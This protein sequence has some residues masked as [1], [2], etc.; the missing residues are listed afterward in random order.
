MKFRMKADLKTSSAADLNN[1]GKGALLLAF[2]ISA[3]L[4]LFVLVVF[5]VRYET[6]DDFAIVTELSGYSSTPVSFILN[7]ITSHSLY[8]LYQKFPSAPWYGLLIYFCTFLA[9]ALLINVLLRAEKPIILFF[10]GPFF[11]IVFFRAYAFP[12]LTFASLLL[13]FAVFLSFL[14][15]YI[16]SAFTPFNSKAFQLFLQ[17]ALFMGFL[18]RWELVSYFLVFSFPVLL[19]YQK[20]IA[21]P[22]QSFIHILV[23]LLLLVPFF[24]FYLDA[25]DNKFYNEYS[26]LRKKFHDTEAGDFYEQSTPPALK[27]VGW[28][29]EDYLL[30]RDYWFLYDLNSFNSEKLSQFLKANSPLQNNSL[31]DHAGKRIKDAY[32]K[33]SQYTNFSLGTLSLILLFTTLHPLGSRNS[34]KWRKRLSISMVVFGILFFIYYRFEPRIFLPLY[35]YLIGLAFLLFNNEKPTKFKNAS[36]FLKKWII[37]L[38]IPAIVITYCLAYSIGK[39]LLKDMETSYT[40]KQYVQSQFNHTDLKGID[41]ENTLLVSLNPLQNLM[42]ETVHPLKERKDFTSFKILPFGW[43]VNSPQY[44]QILKSFGISE[45]NPFIQWAVDNQ[46]V[47]WFQ[48]FRDQTDVTRLRLIENYFNKYIVTDKIAHF[49]PFVDN[50][51]QQ[52]IGFVFYH[53]VIK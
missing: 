45:K 53:L 30:F 42:I 8:Y 9:V 27:K 33:S 43:Q 34:M 37:F 23:C 28:S 6:N 40:I 39:Y 2:G 21:R 48:L 19:F 10:I 1:S 24:V 26:M 52:G 29:Y 13:L 3:V 5:H 32:I 15:W 17:I 36:P 16:S 49:Q 46:R 38:M 41:K 25:Q 11:F 22:Y 20:S 35:T 50:R 51:N 4:L 44:F 14:Q 18:L 12:G 47:I 7:P 31:I